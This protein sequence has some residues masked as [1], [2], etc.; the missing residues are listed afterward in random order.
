[1]EISSPDKE[2]QKLVSPVKKKARDLKKGGIKKPEEASQFFKKIEEESIA[3]LSQ[4]ESFYGSKL[5]AQ[6][7]SNMFY[8]VF[9]PEETS[10]ML[11][12]VS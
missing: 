5:D 3:K 7:Q 12:L 10:N 6:N 4:H 9:E 11:S 2:A 8:P 1:M